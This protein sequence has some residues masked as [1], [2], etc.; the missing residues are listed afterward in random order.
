[1]FMSKCQRVYLVLVISKSRQNICW[2]FNYRGF[3]RKTF[4][5]SSFCCNHVKMTLWEPSQR[6]SLVLRWHQRLCAFSPRTSVPWC[7][8]GGAAVVVGVAGTGRDDR[9]SRTCAAGGEHE[10]HVRRLRL[11]SAGVEATAGRAPSGLRSFVRSPS[12]CAAGIGASR[13]T[14]G[15]VASR[16]HPP[17]ISVGK[18][19]ISEG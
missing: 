11:R 16:C 9:D 13:C 15:T 6:Y 4:F 5:S 12:T 7:W 2:T 10:E 8:T 17:H 3:Q 14:A 19:G 18:A 1:M